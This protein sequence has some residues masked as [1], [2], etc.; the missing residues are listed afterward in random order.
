MA[1]NRDAVSLASGRANRAED[2]RMK[3]PALLHLTRLGYAYLPGKSEE[4]DPDTGILPEVLRAAVTRINGTEISDE[5]SRRLMKDL[6]DRLGEDDLGLGFY[7]IIRDGWNGLQLIDYA[8]P[9]QNRFQAGAEIPCVQGRNRFQPDITLFVNGLPLAMMEV[10]VPEQRGGILAEYDRMCRRYRQGSFRRYLQAA[11]IWIFSNDAEAD[12]QALLPRD[13]VFFTTASGNEFPVYPGPGRKGIPRVAGMDREAERRILENFGLTEIRKQQ[14]YRQWTA[15]DTPTHRMLTGMMAPERFLRLLRYGIRYT[16]GGA[17]DR[18]ELRKQILTWDEMETLRKMDW[19]VRRGVRNW[20]IPCP[21]PG[22]RAPLGAAAASCLRDRI[23]GCR[24]TWITGD[25]T[26]KKRAEEIF[27][28]QIPAEET[29]RCATEEEVRRETVPAEKRM[30]GL[31]SDYGETRMDLRCEYGMKTGEETAAPG[32][33]RIYFLPA[34]NGIYRTDRPLKTRL[35]KENAEA[36]LIT[37]GE[38]EIH[39]GGNYAY[40]LQ[41]ADGSLYCGWTSDLERRVKAHNAGQGA[42]YTRSRRPVELVYWEEYNTREEA[43]RREWQIKQMRRRDKEKLI[44]G[45]TQENSCGTELRL[46][47]R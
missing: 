33:R 16:R 10:K 45:R 22:N 32:G 3:I 40:L 30:H 1:E 19:R 13:G 35:R 37:F 36:I 24:M 27:L 23:P 46:N 47:D 20:T 6:Q 7:S 31:P 39:E 9:K 21:R 26:E 43:M 38:K 8:H 34:E 18:L 14:A 25:E 4:R 12:G 41:C 15:A 5:S 17:P 44:R 2:A 28:R 11:Q 29:L 42:K